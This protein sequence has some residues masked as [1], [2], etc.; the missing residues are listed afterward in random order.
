VL[1]ELALNDAATFKGVQKELTA[2]L[3]ANRSAEV[4]VNRTLKLFGRPAED[5]ATFAT[6]CR[7]AADAAADAEADKL[8]ARLEARIDRLRD[9]I[10]DA[11]LKAQ[12][13]QEQASTSRQSEMISGAGSVLGA[14]FGGRRS[15]SSIS[16]AV[17][18]A[19]T[20]R[21]RTQRTQDRMEQALA[22]VEAKEADLADL[23]N[24]LADEIAEIAARWDD[25]AAAIKTLSVPLERSDVTVE[26]VTLL[27]LPVL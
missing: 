16:G 14:L 5:D 3:I 4:P 10:A 22:R 9:T 26:S 1:P 15:V 8:R 27:W 20:G 21:A 13:L 2:W 24:E 12:H 25:A 18:R 11:Q 17:N 7:E 6:R 19:A 23:E